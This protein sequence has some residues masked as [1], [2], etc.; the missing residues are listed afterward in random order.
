[1]KLTSPDV[2]VQCSLARFDLAE[3]EEYPP[4]A[5]YQRVEWRCALIGFGTALIAKKSL[6]D[7]VY[8][9]ACCGQV[10]R[11]SSNCPGNALQ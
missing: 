9:P 5:G 10:F 11:P 1:M 7:Q 2:V 8:L 6:Q 3:V 4:I